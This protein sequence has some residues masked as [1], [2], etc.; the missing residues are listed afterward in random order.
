MI[1]SI[2]IYSVYVFRRREGERKKR[3][4]ERAPCGRAGGRAGARGER[5]GER[6]LVA[7]SSVVLS[8]TPPLLLVQKKIPSLFIG[9]NSS[10]VGPSP[11]ATF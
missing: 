1:V 11:C 6:E 2:C 8:K 9:D 10:T 3:K 4:E 7:C 5:D